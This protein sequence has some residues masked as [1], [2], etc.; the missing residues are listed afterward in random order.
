MCYNALAYLIL[1]SRAHTHNHVG[2]ALL[3]V[4]LLGAIVIYIYAVICFAFVHES[5]FNPYTRA[6]LVCDTIIQ[7]FV[8]I[9]G[10][11]LVNSLGRVGIYC[12]SDCVH[13]ICMNVI[14][15][16]I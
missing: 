9:I 3:N 4:A 7:C 8:S 6:P 12:H 2:W 15:A 10:D 5:F 13:F 1:P 14:V 16:D 11:G